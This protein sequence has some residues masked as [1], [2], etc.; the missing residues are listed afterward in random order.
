MKQTT[1]QKD[2]NR[3]HHWAVILAGGE[4]V[5]LRSLTRLVSGDE[6][7]KQFCRLLG[8][9][10]LLAQTRRRIFRCFAPDKTLF[11][12]LRS[13]QRFYTKE[14]GDVPSVQKIVQPSNRGTLLAILCSLTRIVQQDER[15]VVAFFPSDH[16]Y[17]DD[18]KF[19]AGVRLALGFAETNPQTVILLGTAATH[20]E[21]EYGWLEASPAASRD[22]LL[23]V[24][25]FW[26]KPSQQM[27]RDLLERGCVWNTFV[28][29]GRARAYLD[30]I[31]SCRPEFYQ[32]W[33][34]LLAG[35]KPI[36]DAKVLKTIYD[37]L[38][39]VD[40]SKAVLAAAPEKLGVLNLGNAGWS[41]LGEPQ[42]VLRMWSETGI[43]NEWMRPGVVQDTAPRALAVA[44]GAEATSEKVIQTYLG[45]DQFLARRPERGAEMRVRRQKSLHLVQHLHA[46]FDNPR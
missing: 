38:P 8:G 29:V 37:R 3:R 43:E 33:E 20:A 35:R 15:A 44:H 2:R 13:H 9:A 25:G 11:V 21:V 32:A 30:M 4:G 10:T 36:T 45:G 31:Q 6:R 18:R 27:A 19:E 39:A 23:R 41:D 7:P 24:K 14:L 28:M 42:R 17:A 26:E 1:T 12:L 5:R 46:R 22:G 16:Y 40:F 34:L